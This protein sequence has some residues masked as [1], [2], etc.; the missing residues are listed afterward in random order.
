MTNGELQF[1]DL[2]VRYKFAPAREYTV[3]WSEFDN[4]SGTLK[5]LQKEDIFPFTKTICLGCRIGLFCRNNPHSN[6]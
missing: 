3:A 4:A 6:G 1:E 2:A 5:P